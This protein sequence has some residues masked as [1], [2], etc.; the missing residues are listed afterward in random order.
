MNVTQFL[1]ECV[2]H[3][4]PTS[5]SKY[6]DGEYNCVQSIDEYNCDNDNY[7]QKLKD[8]LIRSFKCMVEEMDT[9]Y[10]F[11][12][13][14][15][16]ITKQLFWE[17]LVKTPIRWTDYHS[18]IFHNDD[19]LENRTILDSKIELYKNIKKSSAK[20][21][22][23]CNKLLVKAVSL[24]NISHTIQIPFDNWFDKYFETVL[25]ATSQLIETDGNHII[26]TCCGMGAKV[27]ICEL[28]KRFP[29]GVYLDFG[30][31]LDLLCTK[32]DSRGTA[33]KYD[34]HDLLA[35][36][37]DILPPDWQD[38]KYNPI[39]AEAATKLS[40]RVS[41]KKKILCYTHGI[42]HKNLF[43]LKN[44]TSIDW[45]FVDSFEDMLTRNLSTYDFIYS[46]SEPFNISC[47]PE[48]KFIFG[49]HFSNA[50][51]NKMSLIIGSNSIYIQP[52]NWTISLCKKSSICKNLKTACVPF[53]VNTNKFN[54]LV[55]IGSRNKVFIYFKNRNPLELQFVEL[56]LSK[57][58]ITYKIFDYKKQ[59]DEDNYLDYLRVSKY[60]IWIG[61]HESQGFALEESL[62]C[63]VP[64]FVWS[65][66]SM[67]Q[68]YGYNYEANAATTVPY[69]DNC[70]G[71][72]I[73]EIGD[74]YDK[75]NE[76]LLKL[77]TYTPRQYILENLSMYKCE[78]R[79]LEMCNNF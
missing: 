19:F 40:I 74:F 32:T 66:K 60:G 13:L 65:V 27:L 1:S 3:Y 46:P 30:S 55:D 21:I 22:I 12:G 52:S 6:G 24:L 69:W 71:E 54:Q 47:F 28:K 51:T 56:F 26:I 33:S 34:Y 45:D 15:P 49:P 75:F 58:N 8:G 43:A 36:F 38:E 11:I 23:I 53:G 77:E 29:K 42:H 37:R 20:K 62:S 39:Y 41:K 10:S 16:D 79:F 14:W 64:L 17:S 44:Y 50:I 72:V 68:E 2:K 57:L 63:N 70:C 78:Q 59:Y 76:F 18:I 5:F 9:D 25:E 35:A 4:I 31:A 67:N 48:I 73:Y 61:C 7:T